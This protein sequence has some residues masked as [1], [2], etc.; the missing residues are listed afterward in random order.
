[1]SDIDELLESLGGGG[2]MSGLMGKVQEMQGQMAQAQER[3]HAREVV[4]ESGGGMVKVTANGKLEIV[5]VEIEPTVVD[6]RD[7]EMLA[8]LVTAATNVALD[9][10][11]GI[12]AEELGPLAGMLK[13]GG[14]QV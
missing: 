2:G 12:M 1:M 3:A 5:R 13:A 10:A 4:G 11:R 8:D 7:V 6:P 14:L 9:K